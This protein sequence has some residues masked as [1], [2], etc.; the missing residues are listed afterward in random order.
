[1]TRHNPNEASEE[2]AVL[3]EEF[4]ETEE[5]AELFETWQRD[6]QPEFEPLVYSPIDTFLSTS[7]F[8]K[9]FDAYATKCAE[10]MKEIW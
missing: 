8:A 3:A 6:S 1:M 4:L 2:L 10:Q 5:F 7:K 9:A